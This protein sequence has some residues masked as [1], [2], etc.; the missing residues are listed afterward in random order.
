MNQ[1]NNFLVQITDEISTVSVVQMKIDISLIERSVVESYLIE[2][3]FP[4]L[5]ETAQCNYRRYVQKRP[6]K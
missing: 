1:R 3:K 4:L 6:D 5:I 2:I